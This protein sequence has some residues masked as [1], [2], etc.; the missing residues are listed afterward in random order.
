MCSVTKHD[1]K[2]EIDMACDG[3]C[4]LGDGWRERLISWAITG[5]IGLV[6]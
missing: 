2:L 4:N 3:S 6:L 5:Y 1:D